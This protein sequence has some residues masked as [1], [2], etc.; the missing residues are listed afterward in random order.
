MFCLHPILTKKYSEKLNDRGKKTKTNEYHQVPCGRCV[1]CLAR[2]RAEWTYRLTAEQRCASY[3]YFVTLTYDDVNVPLKIFDGKPY[4]VFDK[5]HV[6]KYIKRVRYFCDQFD[7]K[8]KYFLVSEYGGHTHRPHYHAIF[9]AYD[10]KNDKF[11]IFRQILHDTW[12]H[13]FVTIKP[14]NAANI[15]YVTKY[16]VKSL[17]D[18]FEDCKDHVFMLCSKDSYLGKGYEEILDYQN[19]GHIKDPVVFLNG[20]KQVMPRIYREKLGYGSIPQSRSPH[21]RLNMDNYNKFR[22]EYLKKMRKFD[23]T[24]F[25]VWIDKRLM[26]YEDRAKRNQLNRLEKL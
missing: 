13:G 11:D 25:H 8:T 24:A 1:S 19:D 18:E 17:Q 21:P 9:F 16:C 26:H 20:Y 5:S 23:E 6:Q 4:F 12:Q 7:I 14:A 22:T 15:H 2:R 3:A 10:E